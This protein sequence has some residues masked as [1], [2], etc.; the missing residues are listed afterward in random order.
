MRGGMRGLI[1]PSSFEAKGHDVYIASGLGDT[2]ALRGVRKQVLGVPP[3]GN[4]HPG[5]EALVRLITVSSRLICVVS[6]A[7]DRGKNVASRLADELAKRT[8]APV[9]WAAPS[10]GF[11]SVAE[12]IKD[13]KS[14]FSVEM[15]AIYKP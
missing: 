3:I 13:D 1:I 9:Y 7:T 15:K 8:Y 6:D 14:C 2:A 5:F 11:K 10:M 12:Q 4:R